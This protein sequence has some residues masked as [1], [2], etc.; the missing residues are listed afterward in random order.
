MSHETKQPDS[1]EDETKQPDNK[2]DETKVGVQVQDSNIPPITNLS[3]LQQYLKDAIFIEHSTIPLYLCAW[4]SV[5]DNDDVSALLR[6]VAIQEMDHLR[7]AWNILNAI[8][9]SNHQLNLETYDI[10]PD[11]VNGAKFKFSNFTVRPDLTL[12]LNG[13]NDKQLIQF[14]SVELPD[15]DMSVTD[16]LKQFTAV[17]DGSKKTVDVFYK[18]R[19][20]SIILNTIGDFYKRI[21]DAVAVP[22]IVSKINPNAAYVVNPYSTGSNLPYKTVQQMQ[23]DINLIV[24]EG[25]GASELT[26]K[27]HFHTFLQLYCGY[28][29]DSVTPTTNT[30]NTF[31]YKFS[32]AFNYKQRSIAEYDTTGTIIS[33]YKKLLKQLNKAFNDGGS[34]SQLSEMWALGEVLGDL[35]NKKNLLPKISPGIFQSSPSELFVLTNRL[36]RFV[37]AYEDTKFFINGLIGTWYGDNGKDTIFIQ[38]NGDPVVTPFNETVT[39]ERISYGILNPRTRSKDNSIGDQLGGEVLD[40]V[41]FF[42]RVLSTDNS[43]TAIFKNTI[44]EETGYILFCYINTKQSDGKIVPVFSRVVHSIAIPRALTVLAHDENPT[45]DTTTNTMT[46][47]VQAKNLDPVWVVGNGQFTTSFA[48]ITS[49]TQLSKITIDPVDPSNSRI[50]YYQSTPLFLK[51]YGVTTKHD[52]N[53]I[54]RKQRDRKSVV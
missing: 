47:N 8:S 43:S 52:N 36:P 23:D 11:F 50:Y 29:L 7:I 49:F 28:K 31:T 30:L 14:I 13:L 38:K 54:L 25:E 24:T 4:K 32:D 2:E 33:P 19:D 6:T 10:I 37:A 20:P 27:S 17:K 40:G 18:P 5:L 15:Y 9:Q 48:T 22:T 12:T 1:K 26:L 35:I 3:T 53:N 34:Y 16:I 21:K 44:H 45:F 51:S 41:R 42:R 39:F 46:W